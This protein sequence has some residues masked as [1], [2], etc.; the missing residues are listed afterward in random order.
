MV[1]NQ[2]VIES[3]QGTSGEGVCGFKILVWR[4]V[5]CHAM[6]ALPGRQNAKTF[7]FVSTPSGANECAWIVQGGHSG[8][9]LNFAGKF[10]VFEGQS[11]A[12][13]AGK[14]K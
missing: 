10:Y 11:K 9:C 7:N 3:R 6:H 5:E 4:E 12:N 13:R 1:P 8:S 14:C 2:D